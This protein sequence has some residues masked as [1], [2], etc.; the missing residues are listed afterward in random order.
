MINRDL[1]LQII[2]AI[3]V[4]FIIILSVRHFTQTSPPSPTSLTTQDYKETV[5]E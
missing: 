4:L 1:D 5:D 3:V 2:G